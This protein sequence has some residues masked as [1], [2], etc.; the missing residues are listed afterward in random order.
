[1]FARV[2]LP[3]NLLNCTRSGLH[4]RKPSVRTFTVCSYYGKYGIGINPIHHIYQIPLFF[5]VVLADTKGV[6]PQISFS[7]RIR[8]SNGIS[9]GVRYGSVKV[10]SEAILNHQFAAIRLVK[11]EFWS[12]APNIA[13]GNVPTVFDEV[14][15]N[16]CETTPFYVDNSEECRFL[17]DEGPALLTASSAMFSFTM[18]QPD[19]PNRQVDCA[20]INDIAIAQRV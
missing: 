15:R 10:R 19:T 1:M 7:Y 4:P 9:Y 12:F 13:Q 11:F 2:N 6:H 8:N 18:L 5:V 14:S 3:A 20:W 17:C 16:F